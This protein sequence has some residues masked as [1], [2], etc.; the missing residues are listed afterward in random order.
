VVTAGHPC[1]LA[2]R[3]VAGARAVV[4][5]PMH[6]GSLV[7]YAAG[8]PH[9]FAGDEAFEVASLQAAYKAPE[10]QDFA[11]SVLEDFGGLPQCPYE[12]FLEQSRSVQSGR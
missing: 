10:R 7:L 9:T 8:V 4:V 3:E 6:P 1:F 2:V 12:A 11:P 5:A